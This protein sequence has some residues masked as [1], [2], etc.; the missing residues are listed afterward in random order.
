M[1]ESKS[2]TIETGYTTPMPD[3]LFPMVRHLSYR[4][5]PALAKTPISA[6]QVT[7]LS[8]VCGLVCNG[9]FLVGE[10]A[11]G[12]VGALFFVVTYILDNCDGEIARLKDQCS[13]FGM[14]YDSFVDWIVHSSFFPALGIGVHSATGNEV[15]LWLGWIGGAGGTFNYAV[16]FWVEARNRREKAESYDETGREA[17]ENSH[18]PENLGEWLLFA[19]RELSRADFCFIVLALAVFDLTWLLLPLGAVGA[20][21]YWITQFARRAR[22][23]HV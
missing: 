13:A 16:G 3:T 21:A 4:V 11:W 17:V 9:M 6:N 12:I 2:G 8:L 18:R 20:Q 10:T 14:R 1:S 19:F 7:S 5:T 15:W 22:E 23:F